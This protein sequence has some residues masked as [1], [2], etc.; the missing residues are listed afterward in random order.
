MPSVA[1]PGQVEIAAVLPLRVK[2]GEKAVRFG[3]M[4]AGG[5]DFCEFR[6]EMGAEGAG[7]HPVFGGVRLWEL[8]ILLNV[9][10][11]GARWCRC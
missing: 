10:I 7:F 4:A 6:V 2:T 9:L 3:R 1:W 8:T 5:A 11:F